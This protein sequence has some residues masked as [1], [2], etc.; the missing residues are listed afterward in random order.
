LQQPHGQ[1]ISQLPDAPVM[2]LPVPQKSKGRVLLL[3]GI[4]LALALATVGYLTI[5]R[6]AQER[7]QRENELAVKRAEIMKNIQ[8]MSSDLNGL[9]SQIERVQNQRNRFAGL[10][11][12][13]VTVGANGSFTLVGLELQKLAEEASNAETALNQKLAS[14]RAFRDKAGLTGDPEINAALAKFDRSSV[15][16]NNEGRFPEPSPTD[17]A[18]LANQAQQVQSVIASLPR[19]ELGGDPR[20]N[21]IVT[22]VAGAAVGPVARQ[23]NDT[24]AAF[25]RKYGRSNLNRVATQG[26][27]VDILPPSE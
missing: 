16:P 18:I 6:P 8:E 22:R 13:D 19:T 9:V 24:C 17:I 4:V 1:S 5:I 11:E 27:F 7:T 21:D 14:L 15:Q 12:T 26:G 20:Y 10:Q 2:N 23:F 3:S 25:Q